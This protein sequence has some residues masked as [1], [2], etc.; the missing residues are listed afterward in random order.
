MLSLVVWK[1]N[2]VAAFTVVSPTFLTATLRA[3]HPQRK[4]PRRASTLL[5]QAHSSS[6]NSQNDPQVYWANIG[7]SVA[8]QVQPSVALITPIG[9]R[10]MKSRGTGF[11]MDPK[12]VHGGGN[13]VE[14]DDQEYTYFITA[15]HVAA[16]G[17]D[18]Q[19]TLMNNNVVAET[20]QPQ[21]SNY[22][23]TVLGRNQTLD[24]ALLRIQHNNTS[25]KMPP[26]LEIASEVPLVGTLTF[27]HGYPA[28]RL[29]GPAMT[30]GIVCGIANG[31]GLPS[32]TPFYSAGQ[33]EEEKDSTT[34][35]DN[36]K[37]TTSGSMDTTTF[38]VTNAAM[39]GGMS[40]GPLTDADGKVLGVNALIRPDLRA[41][42]N[43]AVN[44]QEVL[45]FLKQQQE[46][47]AKSISMSDVN[48]KDRI[49]SVYLFNDPMNKKERVSNILQTVVN[50]T[51]DAAND[52][53]MEAHRTGRAEVSK[54]A[55]R[56]EA[57][58]LC[59]ALKQEDLLVEVSLHS[60]K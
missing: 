36:N 43:Y 51:G 38:V 54:F 40:G 37:T 3:D 18:I 28:S 17:Y 11:V 52:I 34:R 19:V 46:Q 22:N 55:Q 5:W 39:A 21:Y 30:N 58:H 6:S 10:Q 15:A 16:P 41:L 13:N 42:G 2:S 24:L 44:A 7:I 8:Q 31:L 25:T 4:A 23:A 35:K 48:E 53:M 56:D 9:V 12:L 29:Q 26:P 59:Q 60:S 47:S 57:E 1:G 49:Y 20:G 14:D 32:D 33:D 45:L 50:V 27:A